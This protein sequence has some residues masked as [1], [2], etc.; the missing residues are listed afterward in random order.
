MVSKSLFLIFSFLYL[1]L[2]PY[3]GFDVQ[4]EIIKKIPFVWMWDKVV[5]V[6]SCFLTL[7]R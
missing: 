5:Y 3:R 1:H 7:L 2:D 6:K 4:E